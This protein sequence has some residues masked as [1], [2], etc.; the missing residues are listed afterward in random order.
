[1][2][3]RFSLLAP[4]FLLPCL[5]SAAPPELRVV[6]NQLKDAAGRV[7]R[8][9]GVNVPSLDW[10]PDGEHLFESI[11]A[12]M[13]GW[14]AKIIRIPLTQDLWYGYDQGKRA[15]DRGA[16]YRKLVDQV[17]KRISAKNGYVILD[18]HWSNGGTWG[19]NVGQHNMPDKNSIVF[20]KDF[21]KHFANNPA[22]LFDLYNEPHDVSWDVWKDGGR[23][24]EASN[25]LSYDSP[26]MQKLLDTV[27]STGARN[28]V[29]AG[30]LDFGYDLRGILDGYA[31]SDKRGN[32]VVYGS[33][34]YPWKQDW[35]G[36]VTPIAQKYP[37]FVGEVG[38]KPWKTGDPPHENVYSEDWAPK[39]IAYMDRLNLGWTAWSFHPSAN[40]CII[41]GWDY[42]PT[43]YWGKYVKA[44]L[45][46]SIQLGKK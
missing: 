13:D 39:V 35:E 22:V 29:I 18:L 23:V 16:S 37:V 7:V 24:E 31:L 26:G 5:C 8:L 42:Q 12:A 40:P 30:G 4:L 9:Q 20:W 25:A 43:P 17:V 15:P 10:S 11:D 33:H 32:G 21:A 46:K 2:R 41:T 3:I 36:C 45:A 14:N 34:I 1:M 28:V 19:K 44:S 6:G 38:T 27:R